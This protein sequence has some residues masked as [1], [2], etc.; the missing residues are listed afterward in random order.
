MANVT[1]I[2]PASA[3][4]TQVIFADG[5]VGSAVDA[6]Y[7][8]SVP[9]SHVGE[10]LEA[11]YSIGIPLRSNTNAITAHAGGGQANAVALTSSINRVTVVA[12]GNDSVRLPVSVAGMQITIINAAASNSMNLYPA[13]GEIINALSADA[14]LA[15][16]A[17][18]TVIAMCAVAGTWN[19]VVTA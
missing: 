11:G 19:T 2:A 9:A 16:A 1:M 8:V 6:T 12:S 13:S 5:S 15:V 3:L 10:L 18:K 7:S 14:A 17:N 4:G